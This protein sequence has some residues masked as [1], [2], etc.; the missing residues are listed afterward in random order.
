MVDQST[1]KHISNSRNYYYLCDVVTY[2]VI[3]AIG[4]YKTLNSTYEK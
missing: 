1:I 3:V 2:D 4:V